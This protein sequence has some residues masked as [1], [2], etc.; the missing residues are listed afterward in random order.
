MTR[1]DGTAKVGVRG[2]LLK[3]AFGA[4]GDNVASRTSTPSPD[5]GSSS[6]AALF[7]GKKMPLKAGFKARNS[8]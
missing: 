3:P 5:V 2:F 7:S 4:K 8:S 1:L 6:L